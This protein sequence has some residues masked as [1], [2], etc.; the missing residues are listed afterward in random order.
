MQPILGFIDESGEAPLSIEKGASRFFAVAAVM[1]EPG[2]F[3]PL[4]DGV[5]ELRRKY[6]QTGEMKSSKI[7]GKDWS[8]RKKILASAGELPFTAHCLLI[9]KSLVRRDG[10]LQYKKSFIKYVHNLLFSDL[11]GAI[12]D[13]HLIADQHGSPEF[14]AGFEKYVLSRSVP[15][16]FQSEA[17]FRFEDSKSQP[18][19]Q[20]A[21][22]IAGS[23]RR[24]A[25]D[26]GDR[27]EE[28]FKLLNGRVITLVEW[29]PDIKPL[30]APSGD[31]KHDADALVR[32]HSINLT[33]EFISQHANAPEEEVRAQVAVLRH[34]YFQAEYNSAS[35]WVGTVALRRHLVEAA[36][37]KLSEHTF[38]TQVMAKLRDE[39]VLLASCT[40]G[41]KLPTRVADLMDFVRM[42]ASMILPLLER[43]NKARD[44]IRTVTSGRV[45][46]FENPAYHPL[47]RRENI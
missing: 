47:R 11:Y 33:A 12:P 42:G 14:M 27:L 7:R 6:F 32:R 23:V 13:L 46:L 31:Q 34:L 35:A 29:P 10:G 5:D 26:Q 18:I 20:L 9:D 16:L 2:Q 43:L 45:D 37:I 3:L 4:H 28:V 21:D 15:D 41:Y 30:P 17:S 22:L 24:A 8:R 40:K 36:G 38:R 25:T 1:A 19:I 44:E 39:G